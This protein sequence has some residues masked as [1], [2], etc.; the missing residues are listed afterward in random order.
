MTHE[1]PNF[2]E[3]RTEPWRFEDVL[4]F[5]RSNFEVKENFA[6]RVGNKSNTSNENQRAGLVLAYAQL[7]DYTFNQVKALFSEHDHFTI[8]IPETRQD[9]NILE[10]NKVFVDLLQK[11]KGADAKIND[12][13]ELFDIP[14]EILTIRNKK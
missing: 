13:P 4:N 6:F 14:K 2:F 12:F 1:M 7:M 3:G 10:L 9:R 5:I 8:A 11:G